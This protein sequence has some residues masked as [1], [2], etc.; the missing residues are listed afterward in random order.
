MNTLYIEC[1]SG[2]SGDMSVGALLDL[3]ANQEVLIN[4]LKSLNIDGFEIKVTKLEKNNLKVCDFDVILEELTNETFKINRNLADI[5]NIINNSTISDNAK[6]IAKKILTI[7]AEAGA[8]VH[9]VSIDEYYF[10]ESGAVDSIIDIVSV[11]ICLDNLSISKVIV[12]DLYD[13]HGFIKTRVGMLSIPVPAVQEITRKYHLKIIVTNIEGELITP[14]GAAIIAGIK[15]GDMLI[16][17]YQV[18][19]I[20]L[21]N[22]KRVYDNEG[23][24][25]MYLLEE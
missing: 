16:E 18:K 24:L 15:T 17:N 1:Y 19:K 3:G 2:I 21:G 4:G 6:R 23:V 10:H 12:S 22:G 5:I 14:T 11:A 8:S 13:G 9:N 7:K 25:R 20:G